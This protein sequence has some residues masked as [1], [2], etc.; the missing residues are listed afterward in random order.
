MKILHVYGD[1]DY[2]ALEFEN[3][4]KGQTVKSI[5]E[6][7]IYTEEEHDGDFY[8]D[9]LEFNEVDEKFAQ[10]I[11]NQICDYD[12]LKHENFYLENETV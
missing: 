3:Y 10:W 11:K 7:F 12:Q 4:F 2:G 6:R 8:M 5:I 9:L 1:D